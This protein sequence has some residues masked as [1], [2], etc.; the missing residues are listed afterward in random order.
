[1]NE[2]LKNAQVLESSRYIVSLVRDP[3]TGKLY[4]RIYDKQTGK[5]LSEEVE[6]IMRDPKDPSSLII[7]TRDKNGNEKTHT[8]KV[9][10]TSDGTPLLKVDGKSGGILKTIQTPNGLMYFDP[11]TGEWKL[12]NG[13]LAPLAEAFKNG[14]KMTFEGGIGKGVPAGGIVINNAPQRQGPGFSLPFMTWEI[15]PVI[16]VVGILFI[17]IK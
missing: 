17:F 10:V 11:T 12:I 15:V 2:A 13:V 5:T 16:L 4:L 6:R 1:M 9:E 14:I 3:K 7:K 8:V